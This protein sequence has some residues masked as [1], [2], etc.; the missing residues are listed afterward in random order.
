IELFNSTEPL[1]ATTDK[2]VN[3]ELNKLLNALNNAMTGNYQDGLSHRLILDTNFLDK[4]NIR[5]W[6]LN[7]L[8]KQRV[9]R[10]IKYIND[11]MTKDYQ[12][13]ISHGLIFDTDS[14][15]EESDVF[16]LKITLGIDN[17]EQQIAN[18]PSPATNIARY[19]KLGDEIVKFI[20]FC[21]HYGITSTQ[22]IEC[23]LKGKFSGRKIYQKCLYDSIL[24]H[25]EF[26]ISDLIRHL[27]S[28]RTKDSCWFVEAKFKKDERQL[29]ELV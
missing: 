20:E 15:D 3:E 21:I 1:N 27:Y 7:S 8:Y 26:D 5:K 23:L 24:T 28:H 19:R 2:A 4:A 18:V 9:K 25:V 11:A 12:D 14:S 16:S 10:I 6:T 17:L 22:S 29:C 13:S